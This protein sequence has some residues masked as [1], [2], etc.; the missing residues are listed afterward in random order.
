MGSS[1]HA[2]AIDSPGIRPSGRSKRIVAK[3]LGN[4][5]KKIKGVP[6]AEG[7]P[8]YSRTGHGT[9]ASRP[10]YRTCGRALKGGM[11][12]TE[13]GASASQGN[14][15]MEIRVSKPGCAVAAP[16]GGSQ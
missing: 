14:H 6:A 16:R 15:R 9:C 1:A 12:L 13:N 11:E 5:E 3:T 7:P 8:P 4:A 2:A 10:M